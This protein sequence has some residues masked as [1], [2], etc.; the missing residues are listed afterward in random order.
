M[1]GLTPDCFIVRYRQKDQTKW[2]DSYYRYRTLREA[3][4]LAK[5]M[6]TREITDTNCPIVE[7]KV[8]VGPEGVCNSLFLDK[9]CI[10]HY[11]RDEKT[12]KRLSK[13]KKKEEEEYTVAQLC[14]WLETEG[15]LNPNVSERMAYAVSKKL[16][17]MDAELKRAKNRIIQRDDK[18][19]ELQRELKREKKA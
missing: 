16:K 5:G 11:V 17:A 19:E 10:E 9:D 2:S 7:A 8:L 1:V 15:D 13:N 6:V 4:E 14:K 12:L 3:R 18:I